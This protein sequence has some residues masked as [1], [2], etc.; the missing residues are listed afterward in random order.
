GDEDQGLMGA[1]SVLLKTGIFSMKGGC[2]VEPYYELSG[3]LFDKITF[4]LNQEY[5]PA[6]SFSL[7]TQ[8]LSLENRYIQ[9]A[10]WRGETWDKAYLMHDDLV[11]GG[12]LILNMG[13]EPK[14]SW[15]REPLPNE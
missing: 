1:L 12:T 15:G 13:S 14:Q 10:S 11:E 7:E 8:N 2:S 3:P 9:S 6:P 4:H 5:Y